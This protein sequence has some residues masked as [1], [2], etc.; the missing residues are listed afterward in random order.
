MKLGSK[1][2]AMLLAL[3]MPLLLMAGCGDNGNSSADGVTSTAADS[4]ATQTAATS[5]KKEPVTIRF[6]WW[7]SANV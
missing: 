7:G 2:L 3:A 5:G 1:I 4:T 6:S